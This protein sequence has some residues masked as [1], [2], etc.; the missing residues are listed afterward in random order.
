VNN[1]FSVQQLPDAAQPTAAAGHRAADGS[2][3]TP[4]SR[5][6]LPNTAQPTAA[7]AA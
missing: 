1:A 4:R 7:A 2:C 5:R 6:Q 3:R